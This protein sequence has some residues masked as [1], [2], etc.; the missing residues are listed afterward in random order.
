M[1][2][3]ETLDKLRERWWWF[4]KDAILG[5]RAFCFSHAGIFLHAK[6]VKLSSRLAPS[7]ECRRRVALRLWFSRRLLTHSLIH[8]F[9]HTLY[10]WLKCM[11]VQ[12]NHVGPIFKVVGP[13]WISTNHEKCVE[14][15]VL[16]GVLL[17]FFFW[18]KVN[19]SY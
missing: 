5:G 8:S 10:N 9:Q 17:V 4:V 16:E 18:K 7:V 13:S 15:S 19:I 1:V 3:W 12:L 14:K 6:I 2:G 11:W